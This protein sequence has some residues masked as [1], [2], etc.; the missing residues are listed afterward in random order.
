MN[1]AFQQNR[2]CFSVFS[3]LLLLAGAFFLS[4]VIFKDLRLALFGKTADGVITKVTERVS[5]SRSSSKRN[6]G[7]SE[8]AYRERTRRVGISYDMHVR[9]TP[10]GGAPVEFKTGSTFGHEHKQGDAVK[11]IYLPGNPSRA[12][13]HTTKQVWMPIGVGF[14]VSTLCLFGGWF[15]RQLV[16]QA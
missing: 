14:V 9:F 3:W 12:E 6:P 1:K 8:S 10:E 11:I 2:G 7:E 13:V 15:L 16:K 4:V 5:S